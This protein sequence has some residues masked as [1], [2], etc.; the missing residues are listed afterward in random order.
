MSKNIQALNHT[1]SA[2]KNTFF[3]INNKLTAGVYPENSEYQ[4]MLQVIGVS[5]TA[6][7]MVK[8]LYENTIGRF[9]CWTASADTPED[10]LIQKV[11]AAYAQLIFAE[12]WYKFPFYSWA[13]K[14]WSEPDFFGKNFIRKLER[15]TSFTA[16]FIFKALYAKLIGCG[17]QTAYELSDGLVTMQVNMNANLIP[18]IDP[19]I[20]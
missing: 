17:A 5:T 16:N 3:Y 9:T 4:T 6:E 8:G 10:I 18:S 1:I 14:I 15:K 20:K 7:Y 13:K 19:R 2:Y 12:A 11:H